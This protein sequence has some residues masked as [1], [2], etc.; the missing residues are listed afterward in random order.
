MSCTLRLKPRTLRN[1]GLS[2]RCMELFSSHLNLLFDIFGVFLIF[3]CIFY[4]FFGEGAS[5]FD[6][7]ISNKNI[8]W[9]ELY[10][11]MISMLFV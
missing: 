11:M 10:Q 9:E 3:I 7:N 5:S 1:P 8:L 6:C 4:S 2:C